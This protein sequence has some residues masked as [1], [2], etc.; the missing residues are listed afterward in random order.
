MLRV[1][2]PKPL[3]V[4]NVCGAF[5]AELRDVNHRCGKVVYG[6]RCAGTFKS[7]LGLVWDECLPCYATGKVGSQTCTECSGWGWRLLG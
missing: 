2:K 6:R 1:K 4:C 5:A 3:A 7:S